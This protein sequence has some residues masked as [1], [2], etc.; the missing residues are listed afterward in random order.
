MDRISD[1]WKKYPLLVVGELP[2]SP[3]G[4]LSLDPAKIGGPECPSLNN[5]YIIVA[6]P[7]DSHDLAIARLE[8]AKVTPDQI[9]VFLR[10]ELPFSHPRQALLGVMEVI[11]GESGEE[12]RARLHG[13]LEAQRQKKLLFALHE[14]SELGIARR[15]SDLEL[16]QALDITRISHALA[17]GYG[18]CPETH[19]KVLRAALATNAPP[20][21]P[22]TGEVPTEK[23]IPEAAALL[24]DCA[25][26]N[27]N[28]RDTL[29]ERTAAL[30]FRARTDLLHQI[31]SCLGILLGGKGHAA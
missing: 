3:P 21:A 8:E 6:L 29:K 25:A 12:F 9:I 2:F 20:P 18:L 26:K 14:A 30:S 27:L 23:L 15:C 13:R 19:R 11:E 28:F 31:E 16:V 7:A 5:F 1:N 17:C 4:A 22:W 10:A 24:H